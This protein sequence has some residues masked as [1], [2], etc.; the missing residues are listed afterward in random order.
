MYVADSGNFLQ[1][2]KFDGNS[3]FVVVNYGTDDGQFDFLRGIGVEL[4][5]A[6]YLFLKQTE[7]RN[8][9]VMET[10]S[11]NGVVTATGATMQV[12]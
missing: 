10:S 4:E 2:Q 6:L 9:T 5:T 7:S 12:D 11:A 3:N 1:D 8:L